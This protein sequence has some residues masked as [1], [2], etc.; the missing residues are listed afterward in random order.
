M[1]NAS[2]VA[3]M[4]RSARAGETLAIG[5]VHKLGA[6]HS[7]DTKV[8]DCVVCIENGAELT[9]SN[10]PERVRQRY[11]LKSSEEVIFVDENIGVD[12]SMNHDLLYFKN[13]LDLGA[14]PVAYFADPDVRVLAHTVAGT[15]HMVEMIKQLALKPMPV[16]E[17]PSI[18]ELINA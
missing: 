14:L 6:M 16:H 13:H 11:G 18:D 10:I 15:D 5:T 8:T 2:K 17:T 9:L 7:P 12:W 1:C 3:S 4:Q